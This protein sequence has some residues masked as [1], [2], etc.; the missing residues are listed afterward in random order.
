MPT[1]VQTTVPHRGLL[2]AVTA[3]ACATTLMGDVLTVDDDG[4]A[5][6]STIQ[7]AIDAAESGDEILVAPGV[8]TE[9]SESFIAAIWE[10][11]LVLRSTSGPEVT[12]LEP[13]ESQVAFDFDA[14]SPDRL[15]IEIDGFT[16]R[17]Q[18]PS[19]GESFTSHPSVLVSRGCDVV[20]RNCIIDGFELGPDSLMS[21]DGGYPPSGTFELEDCRFENNPSCTIKF[22]FLNASITGCTF[23]DNAIRRIEAD[24]GTTLVIEDCTFTK[25][26]NLTLRC[27]GPD[28]DETGFWA[29]DTPSMTV[30]DCR[31]TENNMAITYST[32][33]GNVQ[34]CDFIENE[35]S[36]HVHAGVGSFV[37]VSNCSFIDYVGRGVSNNESGLG[38]VDCTFRPRPGT[39]SRCFMVAGI[40]DTRELLNPYSEE[41]TWT[42]AFSAC[43]F[44]GGSG[45]EGGAGLISS[46]DLAYSEHMHRVGIWDCSFIDNGSSGDGG[47]LWIENA[48]VTVRRCEFINNAS[49]GSGNAIHARFDESAMT[50]DH[51][52]FDVYLEVED[53]TFRNNDGSP[54]SLGA[55]TIFND[56]M[57][58][59]RCLDNDFCGSRID[60]L[61]GEA[62]FEWNNLYADDCWD[63]FPNPHGISAISELDPWIWATVH[64]NDEMAQDFASG[65]A[66]DNAWATVDAPTFPSQAHA[67]AVGVVN[68][69]QRLHNGRSYQLRTWGDLD[70]WSMNAGER[71]SC[72]AHV[73]SDT[74]LVVETEALQVLDIVMASSG[75]AEDHLEWQNQAMFVEVRDAVTQSPLVPVIDDSAGGRWR[76]ELPAHGEY[77]ILSF[78]EVF[79]EA[80]AKHGSTLPQGTRVTRAYEETY[81]VQM[82]FHIKGDVNGDGSVDGGDLSAL[83]GSW[84]THNPD[85]DLNGDGH[86]DGGD[87]S[88]MLAG[89]GGV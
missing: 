10:V 50:G 49:M 30:R 2:A 82:I 39:E 14:W 70:A 28:I 18:L 89:W 71:M 45:A 31:F 1:T 23:E 47:A 16:V 13:G 44:E 20:M 68:D 69:A 34:N 6:F 78:V 64:A 73:Y 67:E 80:S 86:V 42:T 81:D 55:Y 37:G 46:A 27:Q 12:I 19:D 74:L 24:R 9:A 48:C 66:G 57:P 85:L 79:S 36:Y 53:S 77:W 75:A 5:D 54:D 56:G 72:D 15:S 35:S 4:P 63:N 29:E 88:M 32:A 65:G 52:D 33:T 59:A 17:P 22:M 61:G 83:L 7:A 38:V 21:V 51:A 87:L 76:Y 62:F 43:V 84:G 25:N 41:G 8:Y 3:L 58:I 40:A 11:D 60:H 26:P